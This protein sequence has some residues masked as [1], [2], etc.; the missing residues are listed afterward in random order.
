[1][2]D[3]LDVVA[4]GVAHERAVVGGVVLGPD[5]GLV[6][7]LGAGADRGGEERVDRGAVGGDERHVDRAVD[8]VGE[9]AEPERRLVGG[10]EPDHLA[11]V[12]LP[13]A[14]ER[15]EHGVVEGGGGRDVGALDGEVIEH[16]RMLRP[17]APQGIRG[18]SR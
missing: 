9:R 5:A 1:M 3:G 8:P 4:V 2:A 15:R 13:A 11:E 17:V 7:H 14:A 16:P 18:S 10:A 12:H 6:E